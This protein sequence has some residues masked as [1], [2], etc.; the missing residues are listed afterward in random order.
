MCNLVDSVE[1]GCTIGMVSG[2][3]RSTQIITDLSERTP[4]AR[5]WNVPAPI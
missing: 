4:A 2:K 1:S 5:L 3:E